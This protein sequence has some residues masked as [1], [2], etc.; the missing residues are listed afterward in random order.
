MPRVDIV[1]PVLDPGAVGAHSLAL[2][3]LLLHLGYESTVYG[4]ELTDALAHEG[5]LLAQR[6]TG[7]SEDVTIYQLAIGSDVG[8]IVHQLPGRLVLNHHNIT[9]P[10]YFEAWEPNIAVGLQRG[11]LQLAN[12]ATHAVMTLAV[13]EFNAAECRAA[14]CQ[15][16]AVA[17]V[18]FEP[19]L[20]PPDD[21]TVA[22]LSACPGSRWLFVGRLCPNKCQHDVVTAF[23]AYTRAYDAKARLV[24][25][26]GSTPASYGTAV[27]EHAARLGVA[28]QV[29]IAG[30]VTA[31]QL[32]AHYRAADVFVCLSEHE[33]FCVPVLEAWHHGLPVVAFAGAALP[34]TI[35]GAGLLLPSKA[36]P[37]Y[38][39]AAAARVIDD[40]ALRVRLVAAGHRRLEEHFAPA[41]ARRAMT[42][43][44]LPVLPPVRR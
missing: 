7:S 28:E 34:E 17:P 2:R 16:V 13:S 41:V 43:A 3:D 24:L 19:D 42:D 25:V 4:G 32:S 27:A 40:H 44:L 10:S 37:G 33:G 8:D 21:A 15:D 12:L 26:G 11:N 6:P 22:R 1:L 29:E 14:G 9:P 5:R 39:A 23:A 30:S 18:L 38:V 31:A 20:G 35:G 36:S